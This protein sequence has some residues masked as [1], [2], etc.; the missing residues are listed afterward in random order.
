M[1]LPC[2]GTE[3]IDIA[4]VFI[5]FAFCLSRISHSWG[6]RAEMS[7]RLFVLDGKSEGHQTIVA[8]RNI[9]HLIGQQDFLHC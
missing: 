8:L 4:E 7:D 9:F 5:E 2:L 1:S 6:I 3:E